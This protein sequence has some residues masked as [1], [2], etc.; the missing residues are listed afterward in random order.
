MRETRRENQREHVAGITEETKFRG[1][2]IGPKPASRSRV[3]KPAHDRP[4]SEINDPI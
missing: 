3:P 1:D 2:I 4:G